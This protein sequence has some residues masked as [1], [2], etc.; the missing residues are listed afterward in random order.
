MIIISRKLHARGFVLVAFDR[1]INGIELVA[2]LDNDFVALDVVG[3]GSEELGSKGQLTAVGK[4]DQRGTGAVVVGVEQIN[5]LKGRLA[6]PG[7]YRSRNNGGVVAVEGGVVG[8]AARRV[9]WIGELGAG[10]GFD[11]FQLAV[12]IHRHLAGILDGDVVSLQIQ[13]HAAVVV[14][15]VVMHAEARVAPARVSVGA[16]PKILTR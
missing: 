1:E 14:A 8:G 7:I 4:G 15:V 9:V 3:I 13:A 10:D 16:Y 12:H 6:V 5:P 11:H 2:G